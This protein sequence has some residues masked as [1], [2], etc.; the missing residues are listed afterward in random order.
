MKRF[1]RNLFL[2]YPY[3]LKNQTMQN[4][5][6]NPIYL[7]TAILI[8]IQAPVVLSGFANGKAF[9]LSKKYWLNN[10]RGKY[11][12]E[13]KKDATVS[14]LLYSNLELSAKGLSE[15]AFK[16]AYEGYVKLIERGSINEK[17]IL[18]IIDFSQPS[19]KERLFVI[20]MAEEKVLIK[21]LV[22][23][24]KNSGLNYAKSFSNTPESNKSSLGFYLTLGTYEGSNGF[25][26]QLKGLEKNINNNAYDRAIVMHGAD[27][28]SQQFA[29]NHGYI[30]RSLG[31]PA[32][33]TAQTQKIINTIKNGT[34]LF[35]YHPD[36]DYLKK[37]N[38]INS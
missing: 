4:L 24:G 15:N 2:H 5:R 30:G 29:S 3:I 33:P 22:A 32:V 1:Y 36:S 35:I 16:T 27:Y 21:S 20:D 9:H 18:T 14:E 17:G 13:D 10:E 28:V 31:C 19:V 7:I 12:E 26:M 34:V 6:T 25:S 37:S 11:N 23:H 8:L 38:I